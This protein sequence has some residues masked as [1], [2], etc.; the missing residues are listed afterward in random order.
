MSQ[1]QKF[2][3]IVLLLQASK[4]FTQ[5]KKAEIYDK[6]HNLSEFDLIQIQSLLEQEQRLTTQY[7]Q[8]LSSIEKEYS[9]KKLKA[10]Y[11]LA[12]QKT[13]ERESA[14]EEDLLEELA[15]A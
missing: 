9:E 5:E 13:Q 3:D 7:Y 8:S 4:L 2:H 6:L 14:Q 11:K 1:N 15:E 12:E 10:V